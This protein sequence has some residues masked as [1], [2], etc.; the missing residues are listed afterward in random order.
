MVSRCRRYGVSTSKILARSELCRA[1]NLLPAREEPF[2]F[3]FRFF[4]ALFFQLLI[5]A[6]IV[7]EWIEELA[8]TRAPEHVLHGHDHFCAPRHCAFEDAVRIVGHERN[9]H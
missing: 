2:S 6:P 5:D 1:A 4:G 7:A 3:G 8:I 9:S